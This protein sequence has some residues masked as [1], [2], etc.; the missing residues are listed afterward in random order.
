MKANLPEDPLRSRILADGPPSGEQQDAIFTSEIEYVL[1]ACPG[2]GKTWTAARRMLWRFN[3]WE[4]PVGGIA[5]LSFTNVAVTEFRRAVAQ[6]GGSALQRDPHFI[7]TLDSFIE[8]FVLS[9]F[10]YLAMKSVRRP[11]LFS[12]P[13]AIQRNIK[14]WIIWHDQKPVHAWDIVPVFDQGKLTFLKAGTK[15][16][17]DSNACKPV[18]REFAKSGWYT[19][20][21]RSLWACKLIKD[22]PFIAK[23]LAKRF[24][25]VIIDECQDTSG[26]HHFIIKQLQTEGV[27]FTYIGDPDQCIYEFNKADP[28]FFLKLMDSSLAVLSL[29]K[30]RRSNNTIVKA[31]RN[32][33]SQDEMEGLFDVENNFDGAFLIPYDEADV[34]TAVT[35]FETIIDS[36]GDRL[37]NN[38]IVA[39]GASL[40]N[41][42][43]RFGNAD[44]LKGVAKRFA[45][46][47]ALR[48]TLNDH[49][50]ALN[51][52][53]IAFKSLSD[54]GDLLD[55]LDED[56]D[57]TLR[58]RTILWKFIKDKTK[59]PPLSL[60]AVEWVSI[61]RESVSNLFEE[62]GITAKNINRRITSSGIAQS[63]KSS[64][65]ASSDNS[66][67]TMRISTIHKVKG[68]TV[69]ALLLVANAKLVDSL[70]RYLKDKRSTE[71]V[72]LAYVAMTRPQHTLVVALPNK[73]YEKLHSEW[74]D[75]GFTLFN[76]ESNESKQVEL[77]FSTH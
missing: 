46:A 75:I 22:H 63:A 26:F 58:I 16:N 57:K 68:E 52:V 38:V 12:S 48:D 23:L 44:Q 70:S 49:A 28:E 24:P 40:I 54:N 39:R 73:K 10:S 50:G 34:T 15:I 31:A 62:L 71:E 3:N 25:E 60:S 77:D 74:L 47:S 20:S 1:K 8:R 21:H 2:S 5:L 72:R 56:S 76:G 33:G 61:L 69:D 19:H 11:K 65:I 55:E 30:N 51:S 35:E 13:T 18:L 7:G 9:P 53:I 66:R 59:L 41:K 43:T 32:F 27:A 36:Q 4:N 42:L 45:E 67:T 6:I 17:L 14:K 37:K 29:T 64:P